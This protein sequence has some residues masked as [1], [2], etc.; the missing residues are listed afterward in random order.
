MM[1]MRASAG[2]FCHSSDR[3]GGKTDCW[4]AAVTTGDGVGGGGVAEGAGVGVAVG[5]QGLGVAVGVG[6]ITGAQAARAAAIATPKAGNRRLSM[7]LPFI[8]GP[9]GRIIP[10][11]TIDTPL[12]LPYPFGTKHLLG[13]MTILSDPP[14]RID[15]IRLTAERLFRER[16][17]LATSVRDIGEA[18]GMRGASL[19]HHIGSKED[20]LW[21]I[22]SRAADEFFAA[23]RP[24]LA[25]E[26]AAPIK[27]RRAIVAHVGVITRNLDAAGVYF[28]EW[29]HLG[30]ERRAEFTRRRDE[31]EAGL[32]SILWQGIREGHFAAMDEKF[33]ARFV[34]S[35][36]NWTHQWYRPAGAM[37]PEEIGQTLAD[38]LLKGLERMA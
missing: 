20:L 4:A 32:R 22:A 6:T 1:V 18:V 2:P 13:A 9:N 11:A 7:A 12:K 33:A 8:R 23:L 25:E 17:Y 5:G 38:M 10:S 37:T 31:Y 29:R 14:T 19:Y 36:L 28:N 3:I 26:A 35:A 24:V 27:L 15:Q 34:L 21:A 30:D 16:G